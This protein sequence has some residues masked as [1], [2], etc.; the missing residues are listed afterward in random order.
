MSV[1]NDD[2]IE[3][4]FTDEYKKLLTINAV[5]Q[6]LEIV[7]RRI[8]EL[9]TREPTIQ[10]QGTSRIIIQ[11]PGLEDPD[12]IKSLLGQTAKLTFQLVD[13]SVVFDPEKPDRAP[14]G[15]EVLPS[16]D[17]PDYKYIVKKESNGRWRKFS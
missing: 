16:D 15:S 17:N 2:H 9:G 4:L 5:N 8:D 13:Q 6:S 11:V 3:I 10:R 14:V 1:N 12:Q 7:R